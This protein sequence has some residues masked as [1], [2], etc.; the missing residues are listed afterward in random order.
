[1]GVG[2]DRCALV[3]PD[4]L[5]QAESVF[6]QEGRQRPGFLEAFPARLGKHC[7][8]LP[9]ILPEAE[10]APGTEAGNRLGGTPGAP[11]LPCR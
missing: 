2:C 3:C 10:A 11:P 7:W 8:L 4:R 5:R 9:P 6:F 1:M